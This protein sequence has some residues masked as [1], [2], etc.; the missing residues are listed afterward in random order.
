MQQTR[1][2]ARRA[3]PG[4]GA[5]G[6][7]TGDAARRRCET[8]APARRPKESGMAMSPTNQAAAAPVAGGELLGAGPA[9]EGLREA[10]ARLAA[11]GAPVF[12]CGETGAGKALA[13]R[14]IHAA[15]ARRAGPFVAVNCATL[16]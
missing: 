1:A 3:G 4:A 7:A 6:A 10:I 11:S 16:T 14:S 12:L 15:S 5:P 2:A 8:G 13:A 9:A